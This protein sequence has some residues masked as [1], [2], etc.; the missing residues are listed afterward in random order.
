MREIKFRGKSVAINHKGEW[1]YG[2]G[3]IPI[4]LDCV[5]AGRVEI[6]K[7]VTYDELD[8]YS[9]LIDSDE[10]DPE[11]VGQFT[12]LLDKNGVEIYEGDI[13]RNNWDNSFGEFIG[14]LW[15]VKYGEHSTDGFDYYSSDAFGFFYE[16]IKPDKSYGNE[17][18]NIR[19]LPSNGKNDIE[20][21]GNI[22][23]I[24]EEK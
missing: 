18:Y 2:S 8:G 14:G 17:T 22:F 7:I 24:M 9:P 21:V 5:H 3:V 1:V 20:V 12:G 6:F 15:I 13:V 11:T 16:N 4:E 23:E 19:S 10:V